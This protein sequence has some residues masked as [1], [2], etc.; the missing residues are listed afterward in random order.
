M[1]HLT[2]QINFD[3]RQKRKLWLFPYLKLKNIVF[4]PFLFREFVRFST[5][6]FKKTIFQ[7]KILN[8]INDYI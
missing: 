4:L 6:L 8:Q 3:F 5:P 2:T 1:A 7:E